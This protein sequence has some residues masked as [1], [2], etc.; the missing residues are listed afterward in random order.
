MA[1]K[2][3]GYTFDGVSCSRS[4]T[5]FCEPRAA[6]VVAFFS[7]V[8]VHTKGTYARKPF[9]L[10]GWQADE[11]IRPL[12]GEVLWSDEHGCYVRRYRIAWI[13]I[14]RKN[15]KSELLAGVM[16]YLLVADGEESGEIYGCA[17]DRDQ[18]A[19]VFDVAAS[20]VRLSPVLSRRCT[21]KTHVKRIIDTKS[22]S[23]Y[24][25]IAADAAGALGSNPSGV[26]AD[27]ILAWRDR[28][29]WDAL[30]TGMGSGARRQPLMVAATTA[31]N[32]SASFAADM[33]GQMV[34][35]VDTGRPEHVFAYI[36][37]TPRE[38]DP[39]DESQWPYANPALGDFLSLPAM[40]QEAEEA[41]E[42][43][44]AENAFRQFRL[45]QWVQQATRW[46]RLDEWD[47]TAGTV[48]ESSLRG[49]RMWG[50]LDLAAVSD[51]SAWIMLVE[52][53]QPGVE[54]EVLCRFWLPE[55]R[56]DVLERQLQVPL[57]Q[58]VAEGFV[59]TTEG[60]VVDYAEIT[61]AVTGD[62]RRFDA[63]RISFDRMFA[64]QLVQEVDAAL[65]GV[66]V[67]PVAQTFLGLSPGSK[68]LERLIRS[69]AIRHGGNPVLRWMASC[70][71]IRDD[72]ADNIR[73]VKPDRQKSSAR[74]DGITAAITALDGYLRRPQPRTLGRAAFV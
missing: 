26:A 31:G 71:E 55:E 62:C 74:I 20:M 24:Q 14:A 39:W 51:L 25:V 15:G 64:G 61:A 42:S 57:R 67:V 70:V 43:R 33:H 59:I 12:F 73:P 36:R 56:V 48:D 9:H 68:E 41:R 22:N 27:E 19:L 37:N 30:R 58:W 6:H 44:A 60:D 1:S 35:T 29:M 66:D 52:S 72:G 2:R 16:L 47:A 4:G 18:A 3:C 10:T 69:E 46:L 17:R 23:Y 5:H 8:L 28:S 65:K 63:Q 38:A 49:R 7:E 11:I 45:N 21:V 40:R 53:R 13:E 32:D 54:L 34:R 50:G